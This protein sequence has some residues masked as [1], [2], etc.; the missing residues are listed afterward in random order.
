MEK[1]QSRAIKLN[2][3]VLIMYA[4]FCYY[5]MEIARYGGVSRRLPIII[6]TGGLLLLWV[7]FV[8]FGKRTKLSSNRLTKYSKHWYYFAI[9]ALITISSFTVYDVY[10]SAINFNG[11]LSWIIYDLKTTRKVDFEKNNIFEYGIEGVLQDIESEISLPENLYISNEFSL[12]FNE[13]GTITSIE[14]FIHGEN[15]Q[16]EAYSDDMIELLAQKILERL[17]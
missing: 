15:E 17:K 5:V 1:Y 13:E 9:V 14:T 6:I 16:K 4:I 8:I 10:Q 3:I 11:K 12:S 7:L 2:P